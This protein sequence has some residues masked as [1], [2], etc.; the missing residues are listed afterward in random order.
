MSYSSRRAPGPRRNTACPVTTRSLRSP[1]GRPVRWSQYG[2]RFRCEAHRRA[3]RSS[4]AETGGPGPSRCRSCQAP[5]TTTTTTSGRDHGVRGGFARVEA[6]AATSTFCVNT[7]APAGCFRPPGIKWS[8]AAGQ[9]LQA[10]NC[11]RADVL[12]RDG[13]MAF[14]VVG[15][16]KAQSIT[17]VSSKHRVM[18]RGGLCSVP[19]ATIRNADASRATCGFTMVSTRT[20]LP[21]DQETA[22]RAVSESTSPSGDSEPAVSTINADGGGRRYAERTRRYP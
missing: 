14:H 8:G 12:Q 1:L 10:P 6:P 2:R 21:R 7:P 15:K 4:A 3:G 18:F 16:G 17:A 11:A 5:T 19:P 9:E 13:H 22:P 20:R